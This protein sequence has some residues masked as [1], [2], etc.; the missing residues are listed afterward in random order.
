MWWYRLDWSHRFVTSDSIISFALTLSH[1]VV[2]ASPYTCQVSNAYVSC[3]PFH[4]VKLGLTYHYSLHSTANACKCAFCGFFWE[5]HCS[6][7]FIIFFNHSTRTLYIVIFKMLPLNSPSAHGEH[8][9]ANSRMTRHD[10]L[11]ASP[12][13]VSTTCRM[14]AR[15]L[16]R[17][18]AFV[19]LSC[20][21][22]L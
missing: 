15:A 16:G 9:R 12:S 8:K 22:R 7:H 17:Q 13:A 20:S 10:E 2:C 14:P 18:F 21:V 5:W 11:T 1:S 3:T 6:G 19:I 4:C